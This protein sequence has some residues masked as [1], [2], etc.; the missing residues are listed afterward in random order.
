MFEAYAVLAV[1]NDV[2]DVPVAIEDSLGAGRRHGS[3]PMPCAGCD[4]NRCP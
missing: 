2:L 1:V 3:D 4:P